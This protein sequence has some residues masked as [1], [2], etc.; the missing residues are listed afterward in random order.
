VF[1][2]V[3]HS[4]LDIYLV[5]RDSASKSYQG[6]FK[7]RGET[8]AG[9]IVTVATNRPSTPMFMVGYK[10]LL[11]IG[12]FLAP[13]VPPM[14]EK[15]GVT[16]QN[17]PLWFAQEYGR[18]HSRYIPDNDDILG[19]KS[20]FHDALKEAVR[21]IK[22]GK[23]VSSTLETKSGMRSEA[24][25][26]HAIVDD[27]ILYYDEINSRYYTINDMIRLK[28][29]MKSF[30]R[31]D[32]VAIYERLNGQ[33]RHFR[34]AELN[35]TFALPTHPAKFDT[36]SDRDFSNL[37]KKLNIHEYVTLLETAHAIKS[38]PD[39]FE[40]YPYSIA[41]PKD[42]T[43]SGM[44]ISTNW[45]V[46]EKVIYKPKYFEYGADEQIFYVSRDLLGAFFKTTAFQAF[47]EEYEALFEIANTHYYGTYREGQFHRF[48][49][50][51]EIS[52]L[53]ATELS[54][55]GGKGVYNNRERHL[56]SK[57]VAKIK[58]EYDHDPENRKF[59][60]AETLNKARVVM[61]GLEAYCDVMDIYF[62]LDNATMKMTD[63]KTMMLAKI[64]VEKPY[65]YI[66]PAALIKFNPSSATGT[67]L[68]TNHFE[69]AFTEICLAIRML[70]CLSQT[71]PGDMETLVNP[72][73]EY[74]KGD[75]KDF[76]HVA[77]NPDCVW[78]NFKRCFSCIYLLKMVPKP[79]VYE[80][81]NPH[82][83]KSLMV[84]NIF[85]T[86][87][88]AFI[89]FQILSTLAY[90]RAPTYF[91]HPVTMNMLGMSS[92]HGGMRMFIEIMR[93]RAIRDGFCRMAYSDN[94][95]VA[96]Y[97]RNTQ[98]CYFVSYDASKM[99]ASHTEASLRCCLQRLLLAYGVKEGDYNQTNYARIHPGWVRYINLCYP[100]M[101]LKQRACL[102]SRQYNWSGLASGVMGTGQLNTERMIS[103]LALSERHF[104]TN[105]SH[106]DEVLGN[107]QRLGIK[108]TLEKKT[109]YNEIIHGVGEA[110][111]DLLG[112][113]CR[114][115]QPSDPYE[116][117]HCSLA[118]DRLRKAVL[119]R[120]NTN[121]LRATMEKKGRDPAAISA[122]I[123]LFRIVALISIYRVGGF[124]S[125][126]LSAILSNAIRRALMFAGIRPGTTLNLEDETL[127][128]LTAE[129]EFLE[130][131]GPDPITT[132]SMLSQT[133]IMDV[134]SLYECYELT[135][136]PAGYRVV[137]IPGDFTASKVGDRLA[138]ILHTKT[139]PKEQ[140][141]RDSFIMITP[142]FLRTYFFE[143]SGYDD[144]LKLSKDNRTAFFGDATIEDITTGI[145]TLAVN[146]DI[147][148]GAAAFW[149]YRVLEWPVTTDLITWQQ[150]YAHRWA[151]K[152]IAA[153]E[154]LASRTMPRSVFEKLTGKTLPTDA[155]PPISD[156]TSDELMGSAIKEMTKYPPPPPIAPHVATKAE[157]TRVGKLANELKISLPIAELVMKI[158]TADKTDAEVT[159]MLIAIIQ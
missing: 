116:S 66:Y 10:D 124:A 102:G 9:E 14:A 88:F 125:Y 34:L 129:L 6:P 118:T 110:P 67:V 35:F 49:A 113:N 105:Y 131:T 84:R 137:T 72:F 40:Q 79:E 4:L 5:D 130:H 75:L 37:I 122:V 36:L 141:K 142:G 80:R 108:L 28:K 99:E 71:L 98:I 97:D 140:E 57:E 61:T 41:G 39:E 21:Y 86:N 74:M 78:A 123:N 56:T 154:K 157:I 132:T 81:P 16:K 158:P 103:A 121:E 156:L 62:P 53:C 60:F 2:S 50:F 52:L 18:I 148:K 138:K 120:K 135:A 64:N 63:L 100:D 43:I 101:C 32:D 151:L 119:F 139:P 83:K 20:M 26:N 17:F 112:Y 87:S 42:T 159:Q 136:D 106:D 51:R 29:N 82:K 24:L 19:W 76:R 150:S 7:M 68:S 145:R 54:K 146:N 13:L 155:P 93:F 38:G 149:R 15:E 69:G 126:G 45:A 46:Q 3:V 117:L 92:M 48:A 58:E 59:S 12:D 109:T 104:H 89:P 94:V 144:L 70:V 127:Q 96:Y 30:N 27:I 47:K 25:P 85:S 65:P 55:L 152:A 8:K 90:K 33:F 111:L 128:Q 77:G 11:L 31:A 107:M 143:Y 153:D 44:V 23:T 73:V 1:A 115:A 133:A 95:Y 134:P 91:T 147:G 114:K 22:D